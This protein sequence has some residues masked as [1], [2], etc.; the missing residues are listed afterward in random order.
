MPA[1]HGTAPARRGRPRSEAVE[2]AIIEGVLRLLEEGVSI[3][4]L[5]MERV[6][7]T[8]GVGKATVYRRWPGK[9]ALLLAVVGE[10]EEPQAELPG[11]SVR[12][13]LV[14]ILE[15]YRRVGLAKRNSAVLRTMM[16]HVSSHPKL[17]HQ[18]HD[19]VIKV[20]RE[21][22]HG[23]LRRGL[24]SGE[25]RGGLDVELL[26]ELFAG[27]MLTRTVLHEGKDLPEGLAEQIVDSVLGGVRAPE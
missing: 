20:R 5:S 10:L 9:D 8:A 4:A 12:D 2:R 24:E 3:D 21:A 7:R 1:P 19:S 13:D 22:L 18:Y 14:T 27:P 16:S 17:W 23:V 6:A 25:L 11:T 15:W 26:G